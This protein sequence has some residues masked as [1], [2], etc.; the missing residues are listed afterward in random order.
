MKLTLLTDC[1]HIHKITVIM[2]SG[3]G[4]F[5]VFGL[6]VQTDYLR[7]KIHCLAGVLFRQK[8]SNDI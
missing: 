4:Y 2:K 6:I 1:V 5:I 3:N 8:L 7:G